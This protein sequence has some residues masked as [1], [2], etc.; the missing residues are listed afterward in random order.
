MKIPLRYFLILSLLLGAVAL[1]L[2]YRFLQA[3]MGIDHPPTVIAMG[4]LI[5]AFFVFCTVVSRH[6]WEFDENTELFSRSD[7]W[8][9]LV[10]LALIIVA[11]VA[12]QFG[13]GI[14]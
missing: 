7:R 12:G 2:S 10:I 11:V 13:I 6:L 4:A 8:C 1:P 14:E 5:C 3:E 9:C